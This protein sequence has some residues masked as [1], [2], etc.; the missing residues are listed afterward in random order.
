M[1]PLGDLMICPICKLELKAVA[2]QNACRCQNNHSFDIARQGYVNLLVSNQKNSKA[3]G[4]SKEMVQARRDFLGRGHYAP[5]SNAINRQIVAHLMKQ[6]EKRPAVLDIGCGEGYYPLRLWEAATKN[7]YTAEIYGMDISKDAVK[8]A[9]SSLKAGRWLVG[10][11]HFIPLRSNSYTC[12]LSVFSPI[13]SSEVARLLS[14]EGIFLRV[15]PGPDHLLEIRQLIY[16]EVIQGN[17]KL[18]VESFP[19]LTFLHQETVRYPITLNTEEL[20]S[21]VRMTPHFWK[22]TKA[23]KEALNTL[24]ALTVT[25]DMRILVYEKNKEDHHV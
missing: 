12:V 13:L 16:P 5:L 2:G 4:D 22:T 3:P 9:A 21:L 15:L 8:I 14:E 1:E 24:A 11:S 20:L 25:I 18:E 19:E 7:G 17:E 23:D 6:E 10:N